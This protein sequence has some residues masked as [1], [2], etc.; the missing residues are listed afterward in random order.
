MNWNAFWD[1]ITSLIEMPKTL[2]FVGWREIVERLP[3]DA[4]FMKQCLDEMA[5]KFP[6]LASEVEY[7]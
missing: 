3:R 5:A 4:E 1:A 2:R 6:E 7:V